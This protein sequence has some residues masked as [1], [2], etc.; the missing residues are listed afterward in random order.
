MLIPNTPVATIQSGETSDVALPSGTK[1]TFDGAF[2]TEDGS[3]YSGPVSVSVFHLE[4]SDENISS[5]MPGML[6]AKGEDNQAKVLQTFGM[7]NVELRGNAGQKLQIK[8]GHKAQIEMKIDDSQTA[9]APQTIPLW[10]FD[11]AVGYWKQEGEAARQGNFYVGEVSHFSWWNCD[12]FSEPISLTITITDVNGHPLPGIFLSLASSVLGSTTFQSADSQG[13]VSG[14]IPKDRVLTL[15]VYD[16][17]GNL[18]LTQQLGPFS[19]DTVLPAI[20]ITNSN[21]QISKINGTLVKCN[22]TSVSNGY[23]QLIQG[24]PMVMPVIDGNFSFTNLVCDSSQNFI[25]EGFD[26]DTNQETGEINYSFV[27]PQTNVGNLYTCSSFTQFISYQIDD[28]TPVFITYGLGA[29][30]AAGVAVGIS[31]QTPDAQGGINIVSPIIPGTYPISGSCWFGISG[32]VEI[33]PETPNNIEYRLN[34][35]GAVGD[36]VDGTFEGTYQDGGGQTHAVSVVI[37]VKRLQ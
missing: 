8:S 34:H 21:I 24:T 27:P 12:A 25:L 5:L 29:N 30:Q 36:F 28:D 31:G 18:I 4:T 3:H 11:E 9:T 15:E 1:V 37:H 2:E 35:Y 17:C 32:V 23:I 10:H 13:Q 33:S 22:G 19:T 7:I 20:A 14:Y 16:V 6:Y 26:F